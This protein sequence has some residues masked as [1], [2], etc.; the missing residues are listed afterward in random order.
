MLS[1]LPIAD[2]TISL[3]VSPTNKIDSLTKYDIEPAV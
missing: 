1:G 2:L 3:K